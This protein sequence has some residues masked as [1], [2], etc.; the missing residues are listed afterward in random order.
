MLVHGLISKFTCYQVLDR[1]INLAKSLLR[2][3]DM[4]S[5]GGGPAADGEIQD[6]V[7]PR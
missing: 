6:E 2:D 1:V 5:S 3:E 4:S 7:S